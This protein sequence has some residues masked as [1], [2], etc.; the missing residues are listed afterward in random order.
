MK[1]YLLVIHP[2]ENVLVARVA[3]LGTCE[4]QEDVEELM[5]YWQAR[6]GDDFVVLDSRLTESWV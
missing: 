6:V 3:D 4:N 1:G 2:D 5:E